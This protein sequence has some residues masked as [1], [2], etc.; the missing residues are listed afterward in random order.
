MKNSESDL[1]FLFLGL[2]NMGGAIARGIECGNIHA[3]VRSKRVDEEKVKYFYDVE[4]L[5]VGYDAAVIAV[6]PYQ[7]ADFLPTLPD[8][9]LRKEGALISV[10]AG[11]PLSVLKKYCGNKDVN[12]VRTMPNTPL[13]IGCGMVG[14]Y[15]SPEQEY[16][17]AVI[18]KIFCCKDSKVV[19]VQQESDLDKVTAISG[20]GPAY[21]FL[22]AQLLSQGSF[23]EVEIFTLMEEIA[24][25]RNITEFESLN[26]HGDLKGITQEVSGEKRKITDFL[27]SFGRR[28]YDEA[29]A[30][31]LSQE[32][33]KLLVEMTM[34]GAAVFGIHS[35]KEENLTAEQ[36]RQNVTSPNG[37]TAAALERLINGS[38]ELSNIV[39]SAVNAAKNRA[40][41]IA[42]QSD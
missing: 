15:L 12:I 10:I 27:L 3:L 36:L 11:I 2:G 23:S 14:V 1:N 26:Y 34:K 30:M 22:L 28:M 38:G 16:L 39:K 17:K 42:A 20:S 9:L 13:A 19:Y 32:Q 35:A 6:K 25:S 37:T 31:G 33:S 41:E 24:V 21:F 4:D 7:V 5:S 18:E 40:E 8:D 29:L